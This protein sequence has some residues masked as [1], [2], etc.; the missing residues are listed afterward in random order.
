MRPDKPPR[1]VEAPASSPAPPAA[2]PEEA[3]APLDFQWLKMRIT[4]EQDRRQ[5][6]AMI[7]DRLPRAAAE[8]HSS[9]SICV[10]AYGAAFGAGLTRIEYQYPRILIT[11]R[12]EKV[13]YSR[14]RAR[15]EVMSLPEIPGFQIDRAGIP[16]L[17]EVGIL[18]GDKLYYRDREKDQYLTMEEL[19]RR[20]LDR[21]LF[22]KLGE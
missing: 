18:P 16:L 9:L 5:R 4:E 19:T 2:A 15:I 7:L 13:G 10:E 14:E 12:D 22:P 1:P 17:V 11:V 21:A 3:K 6:E 8:L 20:I